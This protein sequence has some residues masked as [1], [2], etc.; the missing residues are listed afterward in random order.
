[1][2]NHEEGTIMST[3]RRKVTIVAVGMVA[4]AIT[5]TALGFLFAPQPGTKTRRQVRY[6]SRRAQVHAR[7]FGRTVRAGLDRALTYGKS[8]VA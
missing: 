7:R 1:M 8:L 3:L 2:Q 6:Y 4:G 5:G